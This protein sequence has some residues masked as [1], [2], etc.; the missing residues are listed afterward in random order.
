LY[1]GQRN[2]NL[3]LITCAKTSFKTGKIMYARFIVL[4]AILATGCQ[5]STDITATTTESTFLTTPLFNTIRPGDIDEAS[6]IADSKINPGNLWVHE[7]GGRPNEISLLSHSGSFLKK[8]T[9]KPSVNKDWEDIAMGGGPIAGSDYLYLA[10]IGDNDLVYPQHCIYRF[11]EPALAL[12][13]VSDLDKLIFEYADGPHD[14]D[15]I[16]VDQSTKDIFIITKNNASSRV[17]KIA[18]PQSTTGVNKAIFSFS[19]PF[20]NVTSASLSEDGKEVLVRTYEKI[21]YWS[22]AKEPNLTLVELMSKQPESL[23]HQAEPQGEA[24]CFKND[25]SGFYTLSERPEII[26]LVTLNFYKRR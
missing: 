1:F 21:Y 3:E 23:I 14:A 8:I 16:L 7:D 19:L 6:G 11:P 25:G 13:E 2:Q 20:T 4:L 22:R 5:K 12:N 10:D 24:I 9:I 26:P 15:A 18:Y 17:Y